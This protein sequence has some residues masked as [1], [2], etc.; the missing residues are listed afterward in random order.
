[1]G[2]NRSL[3]S[4]ITEEENVKKEKSFGSVGIKK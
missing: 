3:K 4:G 1:M 2:K